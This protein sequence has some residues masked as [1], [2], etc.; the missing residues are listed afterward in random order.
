MAIAVVLSIQS[1]SFTCYLKMFSKVDKS[2]VD[3]K[4]YFKVVFINK[5]FKE[6]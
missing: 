1:G 6:F 2:L 4:V 5:L 3:T